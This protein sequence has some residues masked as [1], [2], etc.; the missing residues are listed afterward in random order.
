MKKPV[1]MS[2]VEAGFVFGGGYRW[3]LLRFMTFGLG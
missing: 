1:S 3:L 2:L